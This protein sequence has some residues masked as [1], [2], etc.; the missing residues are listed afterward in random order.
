MDIYRTQKSIPAVAKYF[1]RLISR[2]G[3]SA[4]RRRVETRRSLARMGKLGTQREAQI[5]VA[6]LIKGAVGDNIVAA[7]FLRDLN[8]CCPSIVFDVY[9]ANVGW[10][11]W[12]YEGVA[13]LRNCGQDTAFSYVSGQ[14]DTAFI[15]DDAV[16][17][18]DTMPTLAMASSKR[19]L[20][21][22]ASIKRFHERHQEHVSLP[23]NNSA[24]LAQE[25]LY[26]YSKGRAAGSHFIAG[27]D[28]GGDRYHLAVD[29][30][31]IAKF[32]LAGRRYITV[33][34]G[35]ETSIVTR[36]ESSPKVY[37]QFGKVI[38]EIR[39]VKSEIAFVQIGA[40]T[41]TPIPEVDFN[42]IGQTTLR[43]AASLL[44]GACC[45]IDN[46]SGLVHIASCFGI[47]CCV[48]FGPSSPDYF[49]YDG[50]VAIRPL[51]CGGC[52]WITTDWFNRC[53]RGMTEPVCM[54]TQPPSIVAKGAL[55]LLQ[56]S[57]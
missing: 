45:H 29:D 14:Y 9:T 4:I 55:Q 25:L 49:S 23:Y 15:F 31:A 43:E 10:G 51:E 12:I 47:R 26:K 56:T 17:V 21:I 57:L 44:Q 32:S 20:S 48:V 30:G 36:G 38:A 42:L 5:S 1:A 35:F 8:A 52:W 39:K 18:V 34:N 11:R 7:R 53:P 33:H 13:G 16:K 22:L 50:H 6:V 28:Y 41:S 19:F 27:I 46:D 54:Y 24:V 2:R 40:G 3:P 37:P